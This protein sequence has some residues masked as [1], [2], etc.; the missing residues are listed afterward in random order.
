MKPPVPVTRNTTQKRAIQRVF[1]RA[2]RP[3]TPAEI[4]AAAAGDAPGIGIATVYRALKAMVADGAL[5]TVNLPEQGI[6]YERAELHHHHHFKCNACERVF[7]VPC[8]LDQAACAVPAGFEL[9]RHQLIL[10]GRC[11]PCAKGTA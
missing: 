3:M 2:T 7:D 4:L 10:Y 8:A 6:R 5:A 1:D 11:A 9:E